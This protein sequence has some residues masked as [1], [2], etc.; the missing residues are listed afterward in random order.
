MTTTQKWDRRAIHNELLRQ[1]KTLTGIARDKGLYDS[2][3]RQGIIGASRKGAEAIAEALGVPFREMFPDSYT[4][5]RHDGD[6]TNSKPKRNASP[7]AAHA[8]DTPRSVA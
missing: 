8:A 6:D 5:G 4:L 7:K 1:N 3:C 2:A